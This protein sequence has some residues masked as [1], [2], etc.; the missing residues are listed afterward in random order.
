MY[1]SHVYKNKLKNVMIHALI[2]GLFKFL[3]K[4][5][6]FT[7]C[8]MLSLLFTCFS[9]S[10]LSF[11]HIDLISLC[12]HFPLLATKKRMLLVLH[13]LHFSFNFQFI[14]YLFLLHFFFFLWSFFCLHLLLLLNL[15][16][17]EAYPFSI[18]LLHFLFMLVPEHS[19]SS[20]IVLL[21][22]FF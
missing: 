20:S 11:A 21:L 22:P 16:P 12:L 5:S 4:R 14:L 2:H 3:F 1:V 9:L 17:L 6:L 19:F 15:A 13:V 7:P 18:D 8:P 10:L